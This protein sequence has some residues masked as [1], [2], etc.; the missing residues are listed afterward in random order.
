M[1]EN[2]KIIMGP[3]EERR[4]RKRNEEKNAPESPFSLIEEVLSHGENP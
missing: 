4:R 3:E 2:Q 1:N